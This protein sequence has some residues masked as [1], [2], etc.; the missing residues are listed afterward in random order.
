MWGRLDIVQQRFVIDTGFMVTTSFSGI[1]YLLTIIGC[2][3]M[4][5]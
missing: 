1:G 2:N 5:T 3:K 4:L